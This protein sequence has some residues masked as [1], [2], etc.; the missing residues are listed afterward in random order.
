VADAEE[1]LGPFAGATGRGVRIGVIDSGAHPD[2]PHI[3]RI[4]GGLDMAPDGTADHT[5]AAWADRMGHGTAVVAAIQEKAPETEVF[6]I[7][8]FHT[9]LRTNA[10]TLL[11]AI[12]W[13]VTNGMDLINL[14]LGSTNPAH[15][16]IF[17]RAADHALSAKALIVAAHDVE[18]T[19]FYPGASPGVL[20]VGVDWDCPRHGCRPGGSGG[21]A[22]FASGY[23]R[24]IPGVPQRRNLH[25]VSFATANVT[26]L[27]ARAW[28]SLAGAADPATVRAA[29]LASTVS[30]RG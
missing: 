6:V 9:A 5:P 28:E 19:A 10:A 2:H 15:A 14:S 21:A 4:A 24:P 8:V 20:G 1:D 7:K 11:H 27:A 13:C 17:A 3:V 18:G 23:P 22:V 12:D 29:L 25:G 26:G 16:E 30:G